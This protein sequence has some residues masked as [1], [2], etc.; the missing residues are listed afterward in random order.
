[1]QNDQAKLFPGCF[2]AS[3]LLKLILLGVRSLYIHTAAALEHHLA[4]RHGVRQR[5]QQGVALLTVQEGAAP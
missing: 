4:M 2:L 5:V 1:M 3:S